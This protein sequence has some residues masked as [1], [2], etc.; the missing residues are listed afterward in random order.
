MILEY[1]D[2]LFTLLINIRN[3]F[4]SE[5]IGSVKNN[6]IHKYNYSNYLPIDV[7]K[8]FIDKP[9]IYKLNNK[10]HLSN[11]TFTLIP[12]IESIKLSIDD[13]EIDI[14]ERIKKYDNSF[15]LWMVLFI[16]KL[17]EY[18]KIIININKI[19]SKEKYEFNIKNVE[20]KKLYQ[21]Y[22]NHIE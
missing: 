2:S 22:N 4:T 5:L 20:L 1:V 11:N 21:I 8:L 10:Y 18:D 9:Y 19:L 12:L 17:Q 6:K 14:T 7:Y 16:E 3:R 13:V 15:E